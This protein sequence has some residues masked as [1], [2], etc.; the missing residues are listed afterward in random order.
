[1]RQLCALAIDLGAS[2][3]RGVAGHFDGGA[4]TLTQVHS[5]PNN[6]I[7]VRGSYFWDIL[8]LY[9]ETTAAIRKAA[10]NGPVS[11]AID[12]WA[13]DF[14]LL[15]ERGNLLGNVHS[16]RDPHSAGMKEKFSGMMPDEAFYAHTGLKPADI[17]SL[18]Q[19]MGIRELEKAAYEAA[20]TF[21]FVPDLIQYF[22]TGEKSCNITLAALSGLFDI[23]GRAW[24]E[25]V[26]NKT[27]LKRVF[28]PLAKTG[29]RIGN[30]RYLD[31]AGHIQAISVAAH[32]TMSALAFIPE[33]DER[34]IVL[35]S[36]TWSVLGHTLRQP[37]PSLDAM[38]MGL[39]NEVGFGE[40]LFLLKNLT[41][42][43][44]EQELRREWNEGNDRDSLEKLRM[45]AQN[46]GYQGVFDSQIPEFATPEHMERK[47][48]DALIK[49]GQ[50]PPGDRAALYR[51]VLH[52]LARQYQSAIEDF[53]TLSSRKFEKICVVGGGSKN[54]LLN[55]L[56]ADAC[57]K[58]VVAGPAESTAI[59]NILAQLIALG[60]LKDAEQA[61]ELVCRSF[62]RETFL[63]QGKK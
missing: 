56:T 9:N 33:R 15:D 57:G 14:G 10:N 61:R 63:P 5:F 53:E 22:L 27:A 21:L 40:D 43:W 36:G 34:T 55:Q 44:I 50:P 3:G 32:D 6:I 29:E 1:M 62:K 58:P 49:A 12:G 16:Y 42:L 11:V 28:P 38:R 7:Q 19:L 39:L 17:M 60:E 13:Q 37:V 2:G 23:H 4:L 51:C 30:I 18:F 46:S 48:M 20:E 24:S 45:A 52:S 26:L 47:I 8:H 41:G 31:D 35:S 54:A 25:P 59:G